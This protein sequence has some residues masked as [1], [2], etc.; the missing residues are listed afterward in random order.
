MSVTYPSDRL[1]LRVVSILR[2]VISKYETVLVF[3]EETN[4]DG[5]G[6]GDDA[7]R[8]IVYGAPLCGAELTVMTVAASFVVEFVVAV[9]RSLSLLLVV[10]FVTRRWTPPTVPSPI[11]FDASTVLNMFVVFV[12][13]VVV[14]VVVVRLFSF[15]YFLSDF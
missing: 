4:N 8:R 3:W 11:Q 9:L 2:T 15:F 13:V 14:I 10:S 1:V 7:L 12:V 5:D 6:D